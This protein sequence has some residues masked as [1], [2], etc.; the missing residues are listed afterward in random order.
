MPLAQAHA[1]LELGDEP[2]SMRSLATCIGNDPSN[3]TGLVDRLEA[4]GLVAREPHPSD[5]RV[6]H[7]VLTAAGAALQARLH[8]RL[9]APPAAL[10]GMSKSELDVLV[11][12]LTKLQDDDRP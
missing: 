10:L 7:V 6:T 1:L 3:V 4:R 2:V 11:R 8:E 9:Y 12:A 5:R